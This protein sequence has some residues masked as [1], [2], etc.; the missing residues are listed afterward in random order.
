VDVEKDGKQNNGEELEMLE[1]KRTIK[2]KQ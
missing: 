1:E 2:Q